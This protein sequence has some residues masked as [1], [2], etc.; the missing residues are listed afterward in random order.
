MT[1][2][3]SWSCDVRVMAP[4]DSSPIPVDCSC[5][6]VQRAPP[7]LIHSLKAAGLGLCPPATESQAAYSH[8]LLPALVLSAMLRLHRGSELLNSTQPAGYTL[9][10][11]FCIEIPGNRS[12]T[13]QSRREE[14]EQRRHRLEERVSVLRSS[15][16]APY[17]FTLLKTVDGAR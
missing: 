17:T 1:Q 14:E 9:V 15:P 7:G 11:L 5:P 13:A 8:H 4:R 3:D 12:G 6:P 16:P 10:D 2:S